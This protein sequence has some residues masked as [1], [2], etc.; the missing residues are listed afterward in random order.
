MANYGPK[1]ALARTGF[2]GQV[3][4]L[5]R[6]VANY[7]ATAKDWTIINDTT[8]VPVDTTLPVAADLAVGQTFNIKW[9]GLGTNASRIVPDTGVLIEG[10]ADYT[11]QALG[12]SVTVQWDGAEWQIIGIYNKAGGSFT[13]VDVNT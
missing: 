13:G 7:F 6:V 12:D 4:A 9:V 5:R 1:D 10:A 11:H 3:L 8:T 2:P